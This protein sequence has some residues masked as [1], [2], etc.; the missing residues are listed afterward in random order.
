MTAEEA[1]KLAK[2]AQDSG[3]NFQ[4]AYVMRA[5][6]RKVAEGKRE[7]VIDFPK[8]KLSKADYDWFTTKG[9]KVAYPI[10]TQCQD[11]SIWWE[12]GVIRW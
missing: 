12:L 3:L 5:L 4:R 10:Y 7:L 11:S 2:Q 8:I 6:K 1:A 9:Y